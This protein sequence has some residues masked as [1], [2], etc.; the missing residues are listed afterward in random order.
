MT[1][2]YGHVHVTSC[3]KNFFP[4][5]AV[6]T[7]YNVHAVYATSLVFVRYFEAH[8]EKYILPNVQQVLNAM[9]I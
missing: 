2:D 1:Q 4:A 6:R 9:H 8:L 5:P 7:L 3:G